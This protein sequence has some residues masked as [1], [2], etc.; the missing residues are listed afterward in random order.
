[1]S[2]NPLFQQ[3]VKALLEGEILCQYRH[4]ALTN[5]LS[6]QANLDRVDAYLEPLNRQVRQ[7]SSKD[8]WLCA[9]IHLDSEEA[10]ANVRA[11]FSEVVNHMEALVHWLRLAKNADSH[12]MVIAPGDH[13]TQSK[14][15]AS[16]ENAQDLCRS[17]DALTEKGLFKSSASKTEAKLAAVLNK[18]AEMGYLKKLSGSGTVYQATGKW[19]WLYDTL[20]FIQR[21]EGIEAADES[22]DVDQVEAF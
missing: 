15:L 9:Y 12:G 13:I 3:C 18:L 7:T 22:S 8:A 11:E 6:E 19:S 16:L 14:L 17:L 2:N 5:Y 20:S 10:K 4:E 21:H 1:M